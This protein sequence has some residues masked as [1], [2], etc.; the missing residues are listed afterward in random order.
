[1]AWLVR[2]TN[3]KLAGRA[4]QYLRYDLETAMVL[5]LCPVTGLLGVQHYYL[6]RCW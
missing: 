1:M 6:D 4:G 2:T 5:T 3:D